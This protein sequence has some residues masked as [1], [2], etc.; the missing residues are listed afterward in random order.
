MSKRIRLFVGLLLATTML[1]SAFPTN[2]AVIQDDIFAPQIITDPY[3]YPIE[4]GSDEWS[5]LTIEEK[6]QLTYVD[7]ETAEIMTTNALL[8]TT[9]NYP[10]I[11]DIHAFSDIKEGIEIVKDRFPP[12]DVLISRGDAS[13]VIAE[14]L[15]NC[16]TE[17]IAYGIAIGIYNYVHIPPE[18]APC[19]VL[20]PISGQPSA[21]VYTPNGTPLLAYLD[22]TWDY[23]SYDYDY[24]YDLSLYYEVV[25]DAEL[26]RNPDP[27][28]NCHSYAW[29]SVSAS[30]RY[31][32]N[33]PAK[34]IQDGSYVTATK[35]S[36]NKITYKKNS[37]YTHSGIMGA[38]NTVVSKWGCAGL[39]RHVITSCP[40]YSDYVAVQYWKRA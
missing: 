31:W 2:A 34:Y 25:Y 23:F 27:S 21:Q 11:I 5:R 6:R 19:S 14:Y 16:D 3:E 32:I 35:A 33:N 40:Y 29:H 17:S 26:I 4:P 7:R 24:Y 18:V 36:G 9:L 39:F 28:Y 1:I 10:F 13:T 8:I 15:S 22:L 38:S 20:D 37:V 30:N 12:L